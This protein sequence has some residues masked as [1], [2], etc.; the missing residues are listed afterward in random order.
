LAPK[1]GPSRG[2]LNALFSIFAQA[3]VL[4][5][6]G[7]H[8]GSSLDSILELLGIK[9]EFFK[10]TLGSTFEVLHGCFIYVYTA[11]INCA[12][13]HY[14]LHSFERSHFNLTNQFLDKDSVRRNPAAGTSFRSLPSQVY[15][16]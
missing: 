5:R 9:F 2:R 8:F 3:S 13:F 15:L 10:S 16:I 7:I 4:D 12:E 6:F 11:Q 14:V 1:K